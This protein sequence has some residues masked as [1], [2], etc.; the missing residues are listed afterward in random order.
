MN[1]PD[2][3]ALLKCIQDVFR[4][5]GGTWVSRKHFLQH[6]GLKDSDLFRH[7]ASYTEAVCA[8]GV[9]INP[10]NREHSPEDLLADWG[11]LVRRRRAIPT[12]KQYKLEGSF[13]ATVFERRFG[14]WS[15][16]PAH[17]REFAEGREEWA[18]VLA[19]LPAD[20]PGLP[21]TNIV[22]NRSSPELPRAARGVARHARFDDRPTYGAPLDFRGLRHAPVNENGVV[23]LFGMVA[24]ELGY[25]VEAVQ[26]GF[27]DCEAKREIAPGKWQRVRI[28][29]ESRNFAEHG[30]D[31]NK[32][33][34]IVCWR[35]NWQDRPA[36]VELVELAKVIK[37]LGREE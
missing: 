29:F 26:I 15:T 20:D 18:D 21:G 31:P 1:A 34:V 8:A 25:M 16:V 27:P 13:S 32:C 3:E 35:D 2:L 28:E 12:R 9:Q 19:L 10:A 33:D 6:T 7:F 11:E 37:T 24:Q 5:A 23:F 22:E 17:F 4:N 14:P 30:H 36:Q